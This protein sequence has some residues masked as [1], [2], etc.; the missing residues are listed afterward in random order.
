MN[1][2]YQAIS[3]QLKPV[4]QSTRAQAQEIIDRAIR[5]QMPLPQYR[6]VMAGPTLRSSSP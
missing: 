2:W 6:R 1:T 5:E 3:P 4:A